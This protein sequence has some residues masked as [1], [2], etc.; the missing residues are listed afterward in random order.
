MRFSIWPTP[1]QPWDDIYEITAHCARTGEIVHC[2]DSHTDGRLNPEACRMMGA[3]SILC[4][5]LGRAEGG[6][7][8]LT[9]YAGRERAFH[10]ADERT[11]DLLGGVVAAHLADRG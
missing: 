4:V 3:V 2:H 8:A 7:G 6:L 10:Y 5:P 1:A 11:L 9:V